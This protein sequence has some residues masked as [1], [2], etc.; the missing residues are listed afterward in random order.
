MYPAYYIFYILVPRQPQTRNDC[1][2]GT[3][4]QSKQ[5]SHKKVEQPRQSHLV[6]QHILTIKTLTQNITKKKKKKSMQ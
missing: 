6:Y 4:E 1:D 5:K 3:L 2:F